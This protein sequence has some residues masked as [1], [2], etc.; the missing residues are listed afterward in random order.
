MRPNTLTLTCLLAALLGAAG[1]A[2]GQATEPVS[3]TAFKTGPVI[4]GT[5]KAPAT[6]IQAS[7]PAKRRLLAL[8]DEQ[9]LAEAIVQLMD[10]EDRF[11][12]LSGRPIT[13]T[14]DRQGQFRFQS[15]FPRGVPTVVAASLSGGERLVGFA[16]PSDGTTRLELSVATTIVTEFLRQAAKADGKGME[17]Y[18]R[19]MLSDLAATTQSLLTSGELAVPGLGITERPAMLRAY[20]LAVGEDMGGIGDRWA[21]L[22][23]RRVLAI[24]TIIG[25]GDPGDAGD[26]GRATDALLSQPRA[27]ATDRF[28]HT[29]VVDEGNSRVRKVDAKSSLISAFAGFGRTGFGG[30]LGPARNAILNGPRALAID[31]AG[32]VYIAD[33]LNCRIRR[34]DAMTDVIT[35]IAGNPVPD[36]TGG[37]LAAQT[38]DGGDMRLARFAAPRGLA[39]DPTSGDLFVADSERET[40]FHTIRRLDM[41]TGLVSTVVG[42]PGVEGAFSGDG[43]VPLQARLNFPNQLALDPQ[44]RLLVAD[45]GNHCI[46][47][48]DLAGKSIVT[49][50]G[51]G[52]QKG[53]DPDGRVATE[54]RLDTPYGVAVASDG[55]IFFSE[56]L[57]NRVRT[58]EPDG[59][60]RTLAGGGSDERDGE[61]RYVKLAQPGDLFIDTAGDLLVADTRAARIRKL[62]LRKAFDP[63]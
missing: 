12:R 32:H 18:D 61:A 23:G 37:W 42:Q 26:S 31:P 51:I 36:G 1:C 38:G 16:V 55:R 48:I 14:T 53:A 15:G 22:L 59:T 17:T 52:G 30:D 46:R 29:Y 19:P 58:I 60:V 2:L 8:R 20:A 62:M 28:G 9:P 57:N 10:P 40:V 33:L 43:G 7:Q 34:V 3:L 49:V 56:R 50:A 35:T 63:S 54:T 47:R 4:E 41:K 39:L 13:T 25:T 45:T 11:Y 6:A 24:R 44:G 27:M 21:K 5:V